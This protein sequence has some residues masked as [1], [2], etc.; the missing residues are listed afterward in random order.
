MPEEHE[1]TLSALRARLAPLSDE[2]VAA[3]AYAYLCDPAS[4][5][6]WDDDA[7]R[8]WFQE[9]FSD[10]VWPGDKRLRRILVARGWSYD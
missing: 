4:D 6:E 3:L 9:E 5:S 2:E 1:A 8:E 7:F 10:G